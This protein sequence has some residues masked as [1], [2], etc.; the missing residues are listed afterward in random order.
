MAADAGKRWSGTIGLQTLKTLSSSSPTSPPTPPYFC[1]IN[2]TCSVVLCLS[3]D[4]NKRESKCNILSSNR[5]KD[6]LIQILS[7]W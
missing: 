4:M 3:C 1:N 6:S 2:L 5:Y 7:G